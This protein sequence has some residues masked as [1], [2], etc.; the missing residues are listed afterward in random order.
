MNRFICVLTVSLSILV[1]SM[2]QAQQ[3][4]LCS[5][6]DQKM[7][8]RAERACMNS[9]TCRKDPARCKLY[10]CSMR[11]WCLAS[12]YCDTLNIVCRPAYW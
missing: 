6:H 4:P 8:G 5:A 7:C 10:C 12:R 11:R 3:P 1:T 9:D 2:S